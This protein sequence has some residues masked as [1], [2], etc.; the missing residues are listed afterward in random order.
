VDS[1]RWR[2]D[3]RGAARTKKVVRKSFP[4][5][6]D[7]L[8]ECG[9]WELRQLKGKSKTN[10]FKNPIKFFKR[11]FNEPREYEN[12]IKGVYLGIARDLASRFPA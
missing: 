6:A 7:H 12:Q 11:F 4:V 10:F 1:Q 9:W 3:L 8:N 5:F 2:E